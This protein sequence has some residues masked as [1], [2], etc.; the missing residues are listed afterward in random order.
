MAQRRKIGIIYQYDENWIGG[1]YYIQNLI[2]ALGR[3]PESSMFEL[4]IFTEDTH[5]F[6]ELKDITKYPFLVRGSH[7]IKLPLLKRV[8]NTIGRAINGKNIFSVFINDVEW[9]FPANKERLFKNDQQF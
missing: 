2:A 3:L 1:T 8:V 9:I 7:V 5:Q 4:V 6:D